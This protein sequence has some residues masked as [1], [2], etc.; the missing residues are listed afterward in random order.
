MIDFG[1]IPLMP[2][3]I[4]EGLIDKTY[5]FMIKVKPYEVK[6]YYETEL[7]KKRWV[8]AR[9]QQSKTPIITPESRYSF[10]FTGWDHQLLTFNIHYLS[11]ISYVAIVF[12]TFG[13]YY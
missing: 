7:I 12:G 11:E 9:L 10:Q 6:D 4:P 2:G 1:K 3:A 13:S 5:S 8:I